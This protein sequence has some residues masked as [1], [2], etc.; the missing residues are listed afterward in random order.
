M[1]SLPEGKTLSTDRRVL[2][3]VPSGFGVTIKNITVVNTDLVN[4]ITITLYTDFDGTPR[5][6][7]QRDLI[8][9]AG[10][11]GIDDEERHLHAGDRIEGIASVNGIAEVTIFGDEVSV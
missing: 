6:I 10:G 4:A 8:I 2:Y 5:P 1:S 9:P 11:C 7:T 3:E